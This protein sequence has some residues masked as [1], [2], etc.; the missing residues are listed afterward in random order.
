MVAKYSKKLL[1]GSSNGRG[2][3][4]IDTGSPGTLIHTTPS[5][6]SITDEIWLYGINETTSGN[7]CVVTLQW[8]G[9]S[10]PDDSMTVT[11][12]PLAG[13]DLLA[14]GLVLQNGASL[15]AYAA[16]SGITTIFGYVNR[17]TN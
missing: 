7:E 12:Q 5:G 15:R 6:V 16:Y 2:I 3:T 8:G 11:I 13:L 4:V 14:P 17:I 1:S 9:T 10:D